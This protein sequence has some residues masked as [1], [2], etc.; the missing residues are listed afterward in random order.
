V[1]D[2]DIPAPD[3]AVG[4]LPA[5]LPVPVAPRR[6]PEPD[7]A[8]IRADYQSH[9]MTR[10]AICRKHR[11][12]MATLRKHTSRVRWG[13]GDYDAIDRRIIVDRTMALL[14]LQIEHLETTMKQGKGRAMD[15]ETVLLGNISRNLDKLIELDRAQAPGRENKAETAEM[16]DMRK[17]LAQRIDALVK[18]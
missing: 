17:K 15:K 12:T 9:E 3:G 5:P 18:R 14:E 8:A 16:Q 13:E 6:T 11:I 10:A 4:P 1:H 2:E 7:W